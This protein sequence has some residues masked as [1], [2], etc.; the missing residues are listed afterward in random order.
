MASRRLEVPRGEK[1]ALE[2][3]LSKTLPNVDLAR[4]KQL[5]QLGRVR[6]NGKLAKV[7]R[8]LWG[9]ETIEV[10]DAAPTSAQ[11]VTGV[12]IPVLAS[13]AHFL[14]VAKPSGLTV[15]P[16]PNQV[17]LVELVGTQQQGFDVAGAKV[18]GVVHRLDKDT[19]GC[20]ALAKTD[21]GVAALERGFEEK[22]IEKT[23]LAIVA[24]APPETG[25]LDTAYT[26]TKE[27]KYTT[28]IES[29]RRARLSWKLVERL[30][31]ASLLEINLDTGRTHQIRVQLSEMGWPVLGDRIYGKPSLAGVIVPRLALHALRL[32]VRVPGHEASATMPV[33]ADLAALIEAL[34]AQPC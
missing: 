20:L 1:P 2:K 28:L 26:K 7:G 10:E 27:G 9:G 33:P 15:E 11:P 19:S 24:G 23:Y 22:L 32:E 18:P 25:S 17:S 12:E 5:L 3:F 8:K 34:R 16:E 31:P 29:P 13:T 30:G 14:I 4:A 6:V 21:D